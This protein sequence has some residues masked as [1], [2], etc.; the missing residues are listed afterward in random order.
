MLTLSAT[1]IPRTL[2]MALMGVRDL[3]IINTPPE[4]RLS[5]RTFIS[6]FDQE[7][8]RKAILGEVS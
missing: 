1:P 3:S 6:R 5:I 7:T 2:N 4:D 8:I